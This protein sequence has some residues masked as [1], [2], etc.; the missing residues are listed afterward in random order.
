MT[1]APLAIWAVA[2]VEPSDTTRT[3]ANA[4]TDPVTSWS[5]P[6]MTAASF[7]AGII[8]STLW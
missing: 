1:P 2:S 6:A 8:T 7:Q 3:S 4:P 5:T